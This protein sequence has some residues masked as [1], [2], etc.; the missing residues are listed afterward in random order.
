MQEKPSLQISEIR[1]FDSGGRLQ[2]Y[3]LIS[4]DGRKFLIT[5]KLLNIIKYFNG[6]RSLEQI[7][8]ALDKND[9]LNLS[10][11]DLEEIIGSLLK[12]KGLLRETVVDVPNKP[13][14][15]GKSSPFGLQILSAKVTYQLASRLSF[16]FTEPLFVILSVMLLTTNIYFYL[17]PLSKNIWNIGTAGTEAALQPLLFCLFFLISGLFHEIGHASACV[18]EGGRPGGVGVGLYFLFPSFHIDLNETWRLKRISRV[19][20]DLGGLYFTLMLN[21]LLIITFLLRST[22]VLAIFLFLN[23][24]ILLFNLLPFL[25]T[26]TYWVITDLLGV[27]NL[28]RLVKEQVFKIPGTHPLKL[29]RMERIGFY[30][31]LSL[32]LPFLLLFLGFFL[33]N[34]VFL[35][36]DYPQKISYFIGTLRLSVA[37]LN[38]NQ[39]L[40]ALLGLFYLLLIPVFLI[41]QTACLFKLSFAMKPLKE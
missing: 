3:L 23:A 26:D 4:E 11:T 34:L 15:G 22:E 16:L 18:K 8:V 20:V 41:F 28:H 1:R 10:I 30:V 33:K 13:E 21:S 25:K 32:Y 36:V 19:K 7:K 31:Y 35:A 29:G 2:T 14:K 17:S 6:K 39:M 37:P 38:L 24:L 27:S 40:T 12:P 5:E 9:S